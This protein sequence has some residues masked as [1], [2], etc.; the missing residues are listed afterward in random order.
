MADVGTYPD[1]G[2][3][4]ESEANGWLVGRFAALEALGIPQLVTTR[5]GPDVDRMR[6]DTALAGRHIADPPAHRRLL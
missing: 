4:L 6:H 1:G 2:F 3:R 5:R